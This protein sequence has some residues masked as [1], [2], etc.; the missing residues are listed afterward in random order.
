ML[1][2]FLHQNRLSLT[3]IYSLLSRLHERNKDDALY[4]AFIRQYSL[5]HEINLA[6]IFSVYPNDKYLAKLK[7]FF[8]ELDGTFDNTEKI[9]T[10]VEKYFPSV[11]PSFY[12]L[13]A[14]QFINALP[15]C[16]NDR[17][18]EHFKAAIYELVKQ[19]GQR[20][21]K[22]EDI[23]GIEVIEWNNIIKAWELAAKSKIYALENKNEI[24][25]ISERMKS[26][27]EISNI[28]YPNST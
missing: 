1:S 27:F 11:K 3:N 12:L 18:L 22:Y 21:E 2:G 23:N 16:T 6:D 19:F 20:V 7:V 4:F 17:L 26:I 8:D 13:T 9:S 24:D 5:S 14:L 25:T 15:K 10:L 28:D